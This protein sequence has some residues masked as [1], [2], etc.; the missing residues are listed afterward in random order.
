MVCSTIFFPRSCDVSAR[1]PAAAAARLT[2]VLL[3]I[4][5]VGSR[6]LG[7]LLGGQSLVQR[8]G[9]NRGIGE[10]LAALT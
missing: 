1:K 5:L 6:F 8:D 10:M 2:K 3:F 9:S 4:F 7:N